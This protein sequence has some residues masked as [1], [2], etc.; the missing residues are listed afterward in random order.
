MEAVFP[1][2]LS[3]VTIDD[4][5][6]AA[7]NLTKYTIAD[8]MGFP[9]ARS[10]A[11]MGKK[12]A[13]VIPQTLESNVTLLHQF[14]FGDENYQPSDMVK[15]ISAKISADT[16]MYNEAK[17]IDHVGTDG[18]YIPK[19]TQATKATE[20]TKENESE[21]STSGTDESIIDGETDLEIETD[22]FG[23]ELDQAQS[24]IRVR[25]PPGEPAQ[26]IRAPLRGPRLRIPE[27]R[28]R[29]RLILAA[30]RG[31]PQ[32]TLAAPREVRQ[33]I[34]AH[35]PRNTCRRDRGL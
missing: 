6:P 14:L 34:R 35:R 7:R 28:E 5:I 18:G 3:S 23:N 1:Q 25:T 12:G 26:L 21:S 16:G 20:E 15:K 17:P 22:E 33:L 32:L 10:D 31:A 8:T 27:A 11:N 24:P 29:P 9:A 19:P 13:C 30:P 4:I 2:I